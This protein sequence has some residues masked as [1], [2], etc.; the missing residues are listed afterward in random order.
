MNVVYISSGK[1]NGMYT[2]RERIA[3]PRYVADHYIKT[4]AKDPT[5]AEQK[6]QEYFQKYYASQSDWKLDGFADFDLD[7]WGHGKSVAVM[8]ALRM[9]EKDIWPFGKHMGRTISETPDDYIL[10]WAK[11][12]IWPDMR[13]H[14]SALISRCKGIADER[15]LFK[16]EEE[17]LKKLAEAKAISQYVG[18][19]DER[20]GFKVKLLFIKS[21]DTQFGTSYVYKFQDG[22]GNKIVYFGTISFDNAKEGDV[23]SFV[24]RVKDHQEYLGEKQ[25]II[26][27][28]TKAKRIQNS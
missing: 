9:I 11:K 13:E 18:N 6:A 15:G 25:T 17:K 26:T 1:K 14:E 19:L 5:L 24:A 2:L 23:V 7:E 20:I 12:E 3:R 10:W 16:V 8:Q 28:P 27:R 4:L 21:F 22:A